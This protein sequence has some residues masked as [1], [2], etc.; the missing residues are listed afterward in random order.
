MISSNTG[1]T[2]PKPKLD[3]SGRHHLVKTAI[4]SPALRHLKYLACLL[5][6]S[7]P[8]GATTSININTPVLPSWITRL[9]RSWECR[10]K[11]GQGRHILTTIEYLPTEILRHI[12][13]FLTPDAAACF[14]LCSKSL[15]WKIGDR[16]LTTLRTEGLKDVKLNFLTLL[17]KES[18]NWLVC[19]HCY[20]LHSYQ[21]NQDTFHRWAYEDEPICTQAAGY[22]RFEV[23]LGLRFRHAQMAMKLYRLGVTNNTY[24][25]SLLDAHRATWI[26][27]Y[28]HIS[29]RIAQNNL[30]LKL[31]WRVPLCHGEK[32]IAY[33]HVLNPCV[34]WD[35]L[36]REERLSRLIDCQTRHG[37]GQPCSACTGLRQCEFCSTEFI[38]ACLASDWS[39]GGQAIYLTSWKNLGPCETPFDN[40]WRCHLR[41]KDTTG[42]TSRLSAQFAPGSICEAF[43]S[44]AGLESRGNVLFSKWPLD[45]DAEFLKLL[46]EIGR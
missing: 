10:R 31:E 24:L 19:Y 11:R 18:P 35:H 36:D 8:A 7:V 37:P 1:E 9:L 42:S 45:S 29:S 46:A 4:I 30:L 2:N 43:E 5:K 38:V 15:R 28:L 6:S 17:Q 21:S 32:F 44:Q 25:Q 12:E 13:S 16:C 39:P 14:V 3:S 40:R 22:L 41:N 23:I 34:H 26:C 20:K 33:R 27:P